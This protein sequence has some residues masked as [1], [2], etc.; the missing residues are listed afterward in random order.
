LLMRRT[1]TVLVASIKQLS[2]NSLPVKGR[3]PCA[4]EQG[5]IFHDYA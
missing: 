5:S 4:L 1:K 3:I 2:T